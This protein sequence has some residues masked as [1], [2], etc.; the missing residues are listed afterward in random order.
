MRNDSN[1]SAKSSKSV[2]S[3]IDLKSSG[4]KK[5]QEDLLYCT[6]FDSKIRYF[7]KTSKQLTQLKGNYL[8][9]KK[10]FFVYSI[11]SE[12]KESKTSNLNTQNSN[13]F[14]N[15]KLNQNNNINSRYINTEKCQ[16][17]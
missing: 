11:N 6:P 7:T 5:N 17:H 14:S 2:Y 12:E 8:N 16:F 10:I 1:K 15:Y 13:N 4:N 9:D 3:Q